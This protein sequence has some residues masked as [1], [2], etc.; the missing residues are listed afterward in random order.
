PLPRDFDVNHWAKGPRDEIS[1]EL[2]ALAEKR[3]TAGLDEFARIVQTQLMLSNM[4]LGTM[5]ESR[6]TLMRSVY[7]C[8]TK[9]LGDALTPDLEALTLNNIPA[10]YREAVNKAFVDGVRLFRDRSILI[11]TVDQ[12]WVRHLTDL[13]DLREGIGL[14][15]Y[16]QR[17]PL[18]SFRTE[19]SNTY[20]DLLDSIRE[21]VSLRIFNVQFNTNA[22][23]AP[24]QHGQPQ[25]LQRTPA[26]AVPMHASGGAEGAKSAPV[27]VAT[28]SRVGRNDVCPFCNSG[29][30]VKHC[31]CEGARR[32]RGEI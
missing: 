7:A 15:A 2:Q 22:Q 31:D 29:K 30:K 26:K 28:K 5:K 6:D 27:K 18:V 25:A 14:R 24:R 8:A 13:D 11:Q 1:T 21:Q 20:S 12:L 23:P 17:D 16:A 10:D 32:Y 3:Y 4:T 9:S 19:A